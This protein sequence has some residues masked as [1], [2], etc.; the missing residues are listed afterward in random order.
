MAALLGWPRSYGAGVTEGR[1][2][3][4]VELRT[5]RQTRED[6]VVDDRHGPEH[7]DSAELLGERERR[8]EHVAAAPILFAR[9]VDAHDRGKPARARVQ[10]PRDTLAGAADADGRG[11]R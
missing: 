8:C 9:D 3:P 11:K 5:Q 2:S 6:R 7:V 4:G 10:G 1:R